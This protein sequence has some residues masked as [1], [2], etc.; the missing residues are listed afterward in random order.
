MGTG[1]NS[2]AWGDAGVQNIAVIVDELMDTQEIV[3]K[4]LG[5]H[6]ARIP[7]Y[8]GATIRPNGDVAMVLD[9]VGISYY[10]STVALP[11]RA[12]MGVRA[13]P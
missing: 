7:I 13:L 5:E 11:D 2:G 3:V 8:Q 1:V 12:R 4:N 10:E 9:L 6:L